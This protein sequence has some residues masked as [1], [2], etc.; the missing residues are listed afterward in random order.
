MI[1]QTI[2]H[3]HIVEKLGGGGMGV[4][5]KAEDTRLDRFVALKFLP[6]DVAQDRQALE[7]FRREARAASALN[8]PNICTIHDIGE[9]DGQAFIAMEFLEGMTLKHRIAG[10]PLETDLLLSLSI[11]IADALDAAHS[12][13]IIHRDIKPANIFITKR[14]HAKV[15]DFGLAK[16]SEPGEKRES[17]SGSDDP[18]LGEKDLTSKNSTLGTVNY[19]SPEQVAGKPLDARTD[20]F[21]FGVTLYEMASGHLPFERET[22]G[23]TFGAI[24]HEGAELPSH[25]NPQLPPKLDEIISKA[26]EKDRTLRYQH[27]SEMRSDL[28][29]LKRDTDSGKSAAVTESAHWRPV[30]KPRSR[31]GR[32]VLLGLTGVLVVTALLLG[33]NAV[34]GWRERLLGKEAGARIHSLAVLPLANLSGD[35]EQEYF[36]DGMTE[37]LIT[38]LS[39]IGSLKVISRTSVMRYKDARKPLREIGRELGVEGVIEGSVR[40]VGDRVRITAQL[41]YAPSD[42]HLWAESY[43]RDLHDVLQLQGEVAQVIA[44]EVNAK[45]T[46]QEQAGLS[47]KRPVDPEAYQA[48]LQG[49]YYWNK[50]TEEDIRKAIVYFQQAIN[51][52]PNYALAYAGLADSYLVLSLYSSAPW[53]DTYRQAKAAATKALEID[54]N[55]AEAHATLASTRAGEQWDLAGALTELARAIQLSP[56]YATGHQWYAEYLICSGDSEKAIAEIRRAQDLD[57]L[58]LVI[59]STY[60]SILFQA[61]RYDEA[62]AQ[63]RKTLGMDAN[64]YLGHQL[65][66]EV[67]EQRGMFEEAITERQRAATLAGESAEEV[68][69]RALLLRS[70]YARKGAQAY[71]QERLQLAM[72]D[73]KQSKDLPYELTDSSPYR[74]A[75]LNARA[76]R[77]EAAIGLLQ[78]ALNERDFGLYYLKTA[79]ALD[80][81]RSDPRVASL[82]LRIGVTQ[83]Q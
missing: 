49:R 39:K 14:G 21:S 75:V 72:K 70:A 65:L 20:L 77:N 57:P 17:D 47:G 81:L 44:N 67:Y 40:R 41:I 46:P 34:S 59:N 71:W 30:E 48:Y 37:E 29:R 55:L 64:F 60:G 13:G 1:G 4:V 26:L 8:H 31:A 38:D 32:K 24:L 80:G 10:R 73:A 56:N 22:T 19:M 79:P 61:R 25:W 12:A 6:E 7:R 11:E 2:S 82:M 35:P 36:A 9:Q 78:K 5:Y 33:L 63:A 43:D 3:Y 83:N 50:R 52:D 53:Q 54:D 74:L 45:V 15:L 68:G 27:A 69:R 66:A 42:T 62:L 76:G 58:S 23:A 51:K 18:T 16:K 28:Q